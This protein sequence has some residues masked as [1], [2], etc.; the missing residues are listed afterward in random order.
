MNILKDM[1]SSGSKISSKRVITAVG[2]LLITIC[3][4]SE[5]FFDFTVAENTFKYL[6]YLVEIGLGSIVLEKFA[7]K[8][9][10]KTEKKADE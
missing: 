4:L 7:K 1:L 10:A 6:I 8:D 9:G 2:I 5:L 3:T